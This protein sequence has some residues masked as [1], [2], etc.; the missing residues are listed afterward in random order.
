MQSESQS[1]LGLEVAGERSIPQNRV[2]RRCGG[3][4]EGIKQAIPRRADGK[5]NRII[6]T[7]NENFTVIASGWCFCG[8]LFLCD[9]EFLAAA[10][11]VSKLDQGVGKI[12]RFDPELIFDAT[13]DLVEIAGENRVQF[14]Q[15]DV[16]APR[17]R[18]RAQL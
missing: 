13:L 3:S 10:V 8:R 16:A 15:S 1:Q 2:Q 18:Q 9:F 5:Q 17:A 6:N 12:A 14:T 4:T 11:F 7:G